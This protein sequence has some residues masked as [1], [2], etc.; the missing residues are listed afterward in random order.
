MKIVSSDLEYIIKMIGDDLLLL[1]DTNIFITG[2]TGFIGKWLLETIIFANEKNLLNCRATVLTRNSKRFLDKY[3]HFTSQG[4]INFHNGDI[5]DFKFPEGHFDF[6]IHAAT[7]A[8]AKMNIEDPLLMTDVIVNGTRHTLDFARYCK[9]KKVLFL[10]SGAVYGKQSDD[11]KAFP[12]DFIGAPDPL[13]PGTAYGE[14]KRLA[15]FLCAVY[16]RQYS[17]SVSVARCFAFVGPYLSLDQ[18]YAIG[19]FIN[20][21]INKRDIIITSNGKPLR[22]YMYAADMIIWL[23]TILMKGESCE[24]YNVGSDEAISIKELA[25]KIANFFPG[26][27]VKILNQIKATDRNQNYIPDIRK[28]KDK[29]NF[30]KGIDLNEAIYKTIQSNIV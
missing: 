3:P 26:L 19:N 25:L 5:R 12:E 6:I 11:L 18:H 1:K 30:Q 22:S 23:L 20:D 24:A 28:A 2:G 16:S 9:T 8:S 13:A 7:E 29:F 21:G 17:I 15:E 27:N 4:F 14:S 10:S